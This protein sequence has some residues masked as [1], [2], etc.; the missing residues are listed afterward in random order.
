MTSVLP[1]LNSSGREA[2]QLHSMSSVPYEEPWFVQRMTSIW[3]RSHTAFEEMHLSWGTGA[4]RREAVFAPLPRRVRVRTLE[5]RIAFLGWAARE[6]KGRVS[7]RRRVSRSILM[8]YCL[9]MMS[10]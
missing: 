1:S 7:V 4:T 8:E 5:R 2:L 6:R 3:K 9:V 10:F